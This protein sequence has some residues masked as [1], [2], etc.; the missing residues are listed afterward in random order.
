MAIRDLATDKQIERYI[1]RDPVGG[2]ADARIKEYA[3]PVWALVAYFHS[4]QGDRQ[5]V[6]D[7]YEIPID[8]VD[9]ALKFYQRHRQV[10]DARIDANSLDLMSFRWQRCIS[11]RMSR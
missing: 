6:A 2:V 11:M 5:R 8:A 9:A 10:I 1:E 7:D 4:A 3:V